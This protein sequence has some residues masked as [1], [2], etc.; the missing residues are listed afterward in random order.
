[1][2]Y[3][4]INQTKHTFACQMLTNYISKDWIISQLGHRDY[5]M[6]LKHYGKFI[7]DDT[8]LLAEIV[9]QQLGLDFDKLNAEIAHQMPMEKPKSI[10][11]LIYKIYFGADGETWFYH[12][13][14]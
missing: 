10:K 5:T 8:P 3:R 12:L 13:T 4:P 9:D 2:V 11:R 1:M 14:Y 6:L 7:P